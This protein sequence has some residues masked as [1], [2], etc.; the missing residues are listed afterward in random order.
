MTEK[1]NLIRSFK[2]FSEAEDRIYQKLFVKSFYLL[3]ILSVIIFYKLSAALI[4][5]VPVLQAVFMFAGA[6]ALAKINP[7]EEAVFV[8]SP[9]DLAELITPF[10]LAW[11]FLA[12]IAILI[13]QGVA[14]GLIGLAICFP[15]ILT[16]ILSGLITVRL[17][18]RLQ[19][20]GASEC[21]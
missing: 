21:Q 2:Q 20:N 15:Y 19:K 12:V 10:T 14:P 9:T 5:S 4:I 3:A 13:P 8:K 7:K 17:G 18:R 16:V 6:R 11:V 1:S